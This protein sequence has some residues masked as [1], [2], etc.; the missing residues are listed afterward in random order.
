[1]FIFYSFA[2]WILQMALLF[3]RRSVAVLRRGITR[4]ILELNQSQS[5]LKS[6]AVLNFH[7][8]LKMSKEQMDELEKNPY[9][10]KYADKIAKLQK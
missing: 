6:R 8:S 5:L 2:T 9:F 3:C 10:S 4:E 1:M 7:T